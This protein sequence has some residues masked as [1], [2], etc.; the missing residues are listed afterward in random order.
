MT[1]D[2]VRDQYEA[3]PYPERDPDDERK[4]LIT[5]SPSK[6]EE[7]DHFIFDGSRDWSAPFRVLVAGGGT[8]DGL[9]QLATRLAEAGRSAEITY[10]DLSSSS[11]KVAEARAAVRGLS[12]ITFLTGSLLDAPELGQFDYIDC[13]GVLHHLPDPAA[14]TTALAAALAPGGG[15]GFMVYAPYGRSGV[16]P[17]QEAYNT[18]FGDL[19]PEEKLSAAKAVQER[20]PAGHPF[21]LNPH[22]GD[23]HTSDAGF[24]DLLLHSR[25]R[26]YSVADLLSLL[27]AGGLSLS[28]FCQPVR[29][30]LSRFAAR[31]DGMPREETWAL[32]EALSGTIKTHVG[33]AVHKSESRGPASWTTGDKVPVLQG[34]PRQVARAVAKT[35]RLPLKLDG[36]SAEMRLPKDAARIF[37][38]LDGRRSLAE[39]GAGTGIDPVAFRTLWARLA[40]LSDWGLL[41]YSN[42]NRV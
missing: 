11:R 35:G 30:D 14:G 13:C 42:L 1:D 40:P 8:G 23:H 19:P 6:P 16:Y 29:Y 2:S 4:R 22:L 15:I 37:S 41:H 10:L 32:A 38:A 31:P 28:G 20:L 27:D 39:I 33:Y 25:D 36:I 17:L 7:I 18:L 9:I 5:G 3:F 12:G 34:D 24:F 26:A 21:R